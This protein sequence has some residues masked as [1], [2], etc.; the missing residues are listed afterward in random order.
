MAVFILAVQANPTPRVHLTNIILNGGYSK[1]T[2]ID[3][4]YT[5][6]DGYGFEICANWQLRSRLSAGLTTDHYYYTI[7]Q[8][9]AVKNWGWSYW[10]KIYNGVI[11]TLQ[12]DPT[13]DVRLQPHQILKT[14]S[15]DLNGELRLP[16]GKYLTVRSDV[17]GGLVWYSRQLWLHE[18]WTR[19]YPSIDYTFKYDFRNY[20]NARCGWVYDLAASVGAELYLTHSVS[21]SVQVGYTHYL[22]ERRDAEFFPLRNNIL[23]NYGVI[24]NY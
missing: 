8:Q 18:F 7:E 5:K 12:N 24:L 21:V 2:G 13:Y 15:I 20:A 6:L 4:S 14:K 16:F 11:A 22:R 17:R 3:R 1:A 19:Y 23:I 9:D 10:Q